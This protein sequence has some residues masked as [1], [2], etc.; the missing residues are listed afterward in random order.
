MF[1]HTVLGIGLVNGLVTA[2]GQGGTTFPTTPGT[3]TGAGAGDLQ[4]LLTSVLNFAGIEGTG[5]TPG[6]G[7]DLFLNLP[8]LLGAAQG[9]LGV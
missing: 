4:D 1:G 2:L 5:Q 6:A 9:S 3:G 7:D 8:G